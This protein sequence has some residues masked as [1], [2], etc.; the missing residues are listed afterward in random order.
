MEQIID[1]VKPELAVV[2]V[3]LYFLGTFLK[4]S[5]TVK[6]K[7]IPL[8]LGGAGIVICAVYVFGTCNCTTRQNLSLAIFT[9]VTQGIIVAGLSTYVNQIIKQAGK[10]E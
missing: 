4:K 9:S 8:I 6:N 3:A 5:Q 1:F 7:Y 10:K 2:A